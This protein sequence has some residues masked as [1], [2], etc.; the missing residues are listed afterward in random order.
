MLRV[1]QH[2]KQS[3]RLASTASVHV[4]LPESPQH[5]EILCTAALPSDQGSGGERFGEGNLK[6]SLINIAHLRFTQYERPL[7]LPSS[8]PP[9]L[10]TPER[11][12][13]EKDL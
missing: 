11:S 1:A 9:P 8:R 3:W 2:D 12:G 4:M 7:R 6:G 10:L 13:L 5:K